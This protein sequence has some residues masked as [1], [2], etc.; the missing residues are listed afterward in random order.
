[1]HPQKGSRSSLRFLS[2]I[3]LP[4][5]QTQT[6]LGRPCVAVETQGFRRAA[7]LG[8]SKRH[9]KPDARRSGRHA[10]GLVTTT[11]WEGARVKRISQ[12][13]APVKA[14]VRG[15]FDRYTRRSETGVLFDG[16]ALA[17]RPR[18]FSA[19]AA[20]RPTSSSECSE[21]SRVSDRTSLLPE[22]NRTPSTTGF[23]NH[24]STDPST[25]H[26]DHGADPAP[27]R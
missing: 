21:S 11:A 26:A 15:L 8:G 10:L 22:Q 16:D 5:S 7:R 25:L 6:S 19:R 1:M 3:E 13:P 23:E 9:G 12:P 20:S 14:Q 24:P 18:S 17:S 2:T 27:E 4:Q